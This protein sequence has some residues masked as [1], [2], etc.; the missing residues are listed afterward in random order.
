MCRVKC[1]HPAL[2]MSFFPH[3]RRFQPCHSRTTFVT[4]SSV[5]AGRLPR[6][7]IVALCFMTM[8]ITRSTRRSDAPSLASRR[9][10]AGSKITEYNREGEWVEHLRLARTSPISRLYQDYRLIPTPGWPSYFHVGKVWLRFV[11]TFRPLIK[12][13]SDFGVSTRREAQRIVAVSARRH[14]RIFCKLL[15]PLV[16]GCDVFHSLHLT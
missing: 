16:S 14:Y 1:L 4:H 13:P 5:T 6:S 8:V 15:N 3:H 7:L 2:N 10:K 12:S 9:S 11:L